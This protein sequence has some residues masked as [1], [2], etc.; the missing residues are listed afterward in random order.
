[1]ALTAPC[2]AGAVDTRAQQLESARPPGIPHG[3]GQHIGALAP[4]LVM[5]LP[6]VCSIITPPQAPMS[7]LRPCVPIWAALLSSYNPCPTFYLS[8]GI[9]ILFMQGVHPL[10]LEGGVFPDVKQGTHPPTLQP[11]TFTDLPAIVRSAM[12]KLPLGC[13]MEPCF[14]SHHNPPR[15]CCGQPDSSCIRVRKISKSFTD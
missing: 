8:T 14:L 2:C 3:C 15:I 12:A 1:M 11:L 13:V 9:Y 4:P 5:S 7:R 6:N 10:R